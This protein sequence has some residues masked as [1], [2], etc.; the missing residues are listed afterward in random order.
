MALVLLR[1]GRV[2]Q[3]ARRAE[4]CGPWRS[5]TFAEPFWLSSAPEGIDDVETI[6]EIF[7]AKKDSC[8][9]RAM[10]RSRVPVAGRNR[11]GLTAV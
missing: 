1:S 8:Y 7:L 2:K 6:R 11:S 4:L 3:L 10:D 9:L 5:I